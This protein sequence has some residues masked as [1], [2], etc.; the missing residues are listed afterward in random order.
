MLARA[1]EVKAEL[2]N[3]KKELQEDSDAD[4][5]LGTDSRIPTNLKL[6]G[7]I[8]ICSFWRVV[9]ILSQNLFGICSEWR[10]LFSIGNVELL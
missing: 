6:N 9:P 8:E 7:V 4:V 1:F 10:E 5:S 3:L 2:P